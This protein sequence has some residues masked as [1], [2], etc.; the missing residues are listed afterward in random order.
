MSPSFTDAPKKK[1][2][3]KETILEN[4]SSIQKSTTY[5]FALNICCCIGIPHS[6]PEM[7]TRAC[8]IL[9][10]ISL[11]LI[12]QQPYQCIP[13]LLPLCLSSLQCTN[14]WA[15]NI[16]SQYSFVSVSQ[17]ANLFLFI[18]VSVPTS[19]EDVQ[20]QSRSWTKS[21]CR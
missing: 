2:K 13:F 3:L 17:K 18:F 12:T 1:K 11:Q 5:Q 9:Q 7:N 4:L 15:K 14:L 16:D 19:L 21:Q 8:I 6:N 10:Y 20:G